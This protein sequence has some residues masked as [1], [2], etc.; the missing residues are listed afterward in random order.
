[1]RTFS[2]IAC[3][4]TGVM[5]GVASMPLPATWSSEER[6]ALVVRNVRTPRTYKRGVALTAPPS[7]PWVVQENISGVSLD[8][9]MPAVLRDTKA[10]S[11]TGRFRSEHDNRCKNGKRKDKKMCYSSCKKYC[12]KNC[13]HFN[14]HKNKKSKYIDEVIRKVCTLFSIA[15]S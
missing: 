7:V 15:I 3:V 14:K 6:A 10:G 2:W 1:M 5:V 8:P 9:C 11:K 4:I 12:R 13:N